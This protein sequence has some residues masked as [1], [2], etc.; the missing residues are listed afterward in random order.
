MWC[1]KDVREEVSVARGSS[2]LGGLGRGR[3]SAEALPDL[4]GAEQQDGFSVPAPPSTAR[5][6][7]PGE[8]FE[9]SPAGLPPRG[10]R[11][12]A[13]PGWGNGGPRPPGGPRGPDPPRLRPP[14][15]PHGA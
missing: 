1:I 13:D 14:T 3:N 15:G 6:I 8:P 5:D 10:T 9:P 12:S 4:P 2:K 11:I 7:L